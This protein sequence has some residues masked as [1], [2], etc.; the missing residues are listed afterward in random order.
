MDLRVALQVMLSNKALATSI[1]LVLTIAKMGLHVRSDVLSTSEN[2]AAT[3]EEAGPFASCCILLADVAR[4]FFR[5]DTSVLV[6]RVNL[7]VIED[8][9]LR[10]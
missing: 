1:A 2:F 8:L 6:T 5:C 10:E 7:K 9:G 3:F 4:D